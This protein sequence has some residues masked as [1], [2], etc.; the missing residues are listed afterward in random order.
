MEVIELDDSDDSDNEAV[1][2]PSPGRSSLKRDVSEAFDFSK[3]SSDDDSSM[4]SSK[5]R[6]RRMSGNQPL[7]GTASSAAVASKPSASGASNFVVML[8]SSDSE[9][10]STS[11]RKTTTT[12][13]RRRRRSKQSSLPTSNTSSAPKFAMSNLSKSM[14]WNE[15]VKG[16]VSHTPTASSGAAAKSRSK[17]SSSLKKSI[18][19]LESTSASKPSP[20]FD[21][22]NDSSDDESPQPSRDSKA[23]ASTASSSS[24]EIHQQLLS[25]LSKKDREKV[26]RLQ[27]ISDYC[28]DL[29]NE[30]SFNPKNAKLQ[31]FKHGNQ[32][33]KVPIHEGDRQELL[34]HI[35]NDKTFAALVADHRTDK[36]YLKHVEMTEIDIYYEL[37]QAMAPPH[38]KALFRIIVVLKCPKHK[39]LANG[40]NIETGVSN[41][42][43]KACASVDAKDV[44]ETS[45]P[46]T[47][48]QR[49]SGTIA[50]YI[51]ARQECEKDPSP[52]S[53]GC[54]AW[55]SEEQQWCHRRLTAIGT[56]H[57]AIGV[58]SLLICFGGDSALK[59]VR[60]FKD[61]HLFTAVNDEFG[62]HLCTCVCHYGYKSIEEQ[63][64]KMYEKVRSISLTLDCF[65]RGIE[66]KNPGFRRPTTTLSQ[67][68]CNSNKTPMVNEPT[69]ENIET[70]YAAEKK[71]RSKLMSSNWANE[72][73]RKKMV[74]N[75]W[76]E[77]RKD[78]QSETMSSNWANKEIRKK[79][80]EGQK[81]SWTRDR[82]DEHKKNWK[83]PKSTMRAAK[84][85]QR[86]S[87]PILSEEHFI[88][89]P[90][91]KTK[92]KDSSKVETNDEMVFACNYCVCAFA[93]GK[94]KPN[95]VYAMKKWRP[96][97][98]IS[99]L[100]NC[101]FSPDIVKGRDFTVQPKKK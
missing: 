41:D 25:M 7:K 19:S 101:K 13:R 32:S 95:K 17:Q 6:R 44:V 97:S 84:T 26:L 99:H 76:T 59:V 24:D 18:G 53:C 40:E 2:D 75:R 5:K 85:K 39:E 63:L 86:N 91:K 83:D 71:R 27:G 89:A 93:K 80:V 23:A 30:Q 11:R 58:P 12:K 45:F 60:K 21:F 90:A 54:L 74:E 68:L 67:A 55:Q 15:G 49:A 62:P 82:R 37:A 46:P 87:N 33:I 14:D 70:A 43:S 72:E 16:S 57:K 50:Q 52:D 35:K 34:D 22:T 69:D 78:D 81:N 20:D 79:M 47:F 65:L 77:D 98:A 64:V 28:R 38:L 31:T 61:K 66:R 9:D 1:K 29:V 88:M 4:S 96:S 36:K 48:I 73:I 51:N 56:Y 8:D 94:I 42:H 10:S 100:G 92:L 3:D